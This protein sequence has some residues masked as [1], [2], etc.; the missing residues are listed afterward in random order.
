MRQSWA[1]A[2]LTARNKGIVSN[3]DFEFQREI[4][5]DNSNMHTIERLINELTMRVRNLSNETSGAV[6]QLQNETSCAC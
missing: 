4:E 6:K 1:T 5:N 3:T 2:P